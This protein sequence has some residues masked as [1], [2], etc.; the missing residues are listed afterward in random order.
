MKTH[1]LSKLMFFF[2]M[3]NNVSA[4]DHANYSKGYAHTLI[5]GLGLGGYSGYY[6][7]VGQFR[8]GFLPCRFFRIFGCKLQIG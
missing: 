2:A 3:G 7:Y 4:Q 5:L 1:I 8:L 6:G